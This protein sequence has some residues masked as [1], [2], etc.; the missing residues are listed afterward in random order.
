MQVSG[1]M[2]RHP[3]CFVGSWQVLSFETVEVS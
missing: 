2:D 1:P 3:T